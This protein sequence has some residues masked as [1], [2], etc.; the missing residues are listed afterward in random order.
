[1]SA[2]LGPIHHWL[3]NKIRLHEE[4]EGRLVEQYKAIYGSE[5][6]EI[7]RTAEDWKIK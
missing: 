2:F 7:V 6:D 3:F 1:M 4:L 5:I